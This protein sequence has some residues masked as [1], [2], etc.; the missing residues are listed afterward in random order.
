MKN[1]KPKQDQDWTKAF[2]KQ[3]VRDVASDG[4]PFVIAFPKD[5]KAFIHSLLVKE[6]ERGARH[7][8]E[9]D[10]DLISNKRKKVIG[11]IIRKI[12]LFENPSLDM[13]ALLD[14]LEH[15]K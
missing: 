3:F 7:Q 2:D 1:M 10:A 13:Q 12:K 5:V 4:H 6:Y 8:A 11:E 15:P 9:L 14:Y